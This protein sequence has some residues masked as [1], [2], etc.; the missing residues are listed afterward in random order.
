MFDSYG[1]RLYPTKDDLFVFALAVRL[2]YVEF[3]KLVECA[4][5]DCGDSARYAYNTAN[6]RDALI[7]SV[8]RDI[9]GWYRQAM[10]EEIRVS[11]DRMTP[12]A[13]RRKSYLPSEVLFR[14]DKPSKYVLNRRKSISASIGR[15]AYPEYVKGND[16][17]K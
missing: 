3:T 10:D 16:L 1:R 5:E 7:L 8:I 4:V 17:K 9:N 14:V 12:A 6:I 11:K 13:V 2:S 15:L